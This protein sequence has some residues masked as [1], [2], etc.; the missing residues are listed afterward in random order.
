MASLSTRV[1]L[2]IY[3]SSIW[4]TG[5]YCFA[6]YKSFQQNKNKRHEMSVAA[7]AERP[8]LEWNAPGTTQP[9]TMNDLGKLAR[10]TFLP[11]LGSMA[12][13]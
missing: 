11:A 10:V 6:N 8:H 12:P 7:G 4:Y 9:L 2:S 5:F 13:S 3:L 1:C